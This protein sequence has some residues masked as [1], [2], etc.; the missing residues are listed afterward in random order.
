MKRAALFILL[1]GLSACSIGKGVGA[2]SGSLYEYGCNRNGDY[3]SPD[4]VCGTEANPAPYDLRPIYFAG[5]PIDDL[6][7]YSS[8][9]EIRKQSTHHSAA[10]FRQADRAQRRAHLRRGQLVRGRALRAW[11]R[12]FRD[13][14]RLGRGQLLPRLGHRAGSHAPAVRQLGPCRFD[15]QV[16]LHGHSGGERDLEPGAALV[17]HRCRPGRHQW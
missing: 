3:C 11:P 1:G 17:R 15:P 6:R 2:A 7:E 10:A 12:G 8:G 5:E 16:D 14:Q 13:R 9:S 4:G